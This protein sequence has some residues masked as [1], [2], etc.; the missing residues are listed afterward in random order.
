MSLNPHEPA[1][2]RLYGKRATNKEMASE[3]KALTDSGL[4]QKEIGAKLGYKDSKS[5]LLYT[6][7]SPRDS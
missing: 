1:R 5:C 6:S 3:I 4:T 7:P 2:K